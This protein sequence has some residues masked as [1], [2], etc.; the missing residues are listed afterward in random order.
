MKVHPDETSHVL[1]R[2]EKKKDRKKRKAFRRLWVK[3]SGIYLQTHYI[4]IV[5]ASVERL[6]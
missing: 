6:I 3:E 4:D 5:V 1:G 2:C